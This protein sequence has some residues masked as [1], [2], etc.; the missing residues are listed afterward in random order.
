[1]T[2]Q[3]SKEMEGGGVGFGGAR[4]VRLGFVR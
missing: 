4:D 3:I 2:L 1:L